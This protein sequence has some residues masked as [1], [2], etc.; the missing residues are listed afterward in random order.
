[1][2]VEAF[3]VSFSLFCAVLMHLFVRVYVTR[4]GFLRSLALRYAK[5]DSSDLAYALSD[6]ISMHLY[7]KPSQRLWVIAGFVFALAIT[8]V[9]IAWMLCGKVNVLALVM[10][11]F[12][13]IGLV[14]FS[15]EF[16]N[17]VFNQQKIAIL[18]AAHCLQVL[19]RGKMLS[20]TP[21]IKIG[22]TYVDLVNWLLSGHEREI[23]SATKSGRPIAI[24]VRQGKPKL[25]LGG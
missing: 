5:H 21:Y 7:M 3:R 18:M 1:V 2:R 4:S 22:N 13:L 16:V 8:S 12:A 11:V 6:A 15:Y 23:A 25:V 20:R 14:T 9:Y 19:H 24:V 10:F 17:I